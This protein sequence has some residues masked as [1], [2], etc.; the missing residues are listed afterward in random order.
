MQNI[1]AQ[2]KTIISFLSFFFLIS[3]IS[4][5]DVSVNQIINAE[6]MFDLHFTNAKR[7]SMVN[8]LN[9]NLQFYKYLH[10]FNLPNSVPL[11]NCFDP[12]LPTMTFKTKQ[13]P[14]KWN[15]AASVVM[16]ADTNQLAF[17]TIAQLSSLLRN[18][19]ISSVQLSR[20][21]INR[22]KKYDDTLHCV[23]SL[24]EK[25]DMEQAKRV[26]ANFAKVIYKSPL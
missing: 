19:I 17:F 13:Q 6:K 7:D 10:G 4:A 12:V 9:A 18:H 16:P 1:S 23:I 22:L 11:P 2:I 5:Q 15:I 26:D 14:I 21:F 3:T 8:Q 24:T 25:I 20:F